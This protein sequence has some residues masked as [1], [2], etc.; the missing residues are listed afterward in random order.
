MR[1]FWKRR[2]I[3]NRNR[4]NRSLKQKIEA[5]LSFLYWGFKKIPFTLV[6]TLQLCFSYDITKWCKCL[7]KNWLLVSKFTWGIWTTSGKD[8]KV[9]KV[10]ISR[11]TFIQNK[12]LLQLKHYIQRI[13]LTLLSTML[14]NL[15]QISKLKSDLNQI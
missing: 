6:Y 13:Y 1:Y 4:K 2:H 10:E 11:V 8:W 7:Y 9:Q 5:S 14:V 3:R 12:T 15:N